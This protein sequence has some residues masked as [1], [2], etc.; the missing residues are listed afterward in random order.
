MKN[1]ILFIIFG[2]FFSCSTEDI[3]IEESYGKFTKLYNNTLW[4]KHTNP[5][6]DFP[7][8]MKFSEDYLFQNLIDLELDPNYSSR[9]YVVEEG[10]FFDSV[11]GETGN[12][13]FE[14]KIEVIENE[15]DKLSCKITDIAFPEY[16]AIWTFEY[17]SSLDLMKMSVECFLNNVSAGLF[18]EPV[19]YEEV[20]EDTFTLSD[21]S[22]V[23]D[24]Y[25]GCI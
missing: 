12:G 1:L 14:Y 18:A 10:T 25:F 4:I 15:G 6:P 3:I 24:L 16:T 11:Y 23:P 19:Y 2:L 9:C 21:C 5:E 8:Y 22:E 20:K 13:G 17:F 7:I